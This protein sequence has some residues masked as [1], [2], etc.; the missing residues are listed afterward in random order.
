[1]WGT[2]PKKKGYLR[3]DGY[4]NPRRPRVTPRCVNNTGRTVVWHVRSETYRVSLEE[5]GVIKREPDDLESQHGPDKED[6]E[7]WVDRKQGSRGV[8]DFSEIT[9]QRAVQQLMDPQMLSSFESTSREGE[10]TGLKLTV[11]LSFLTFTVLPPG[12]RRD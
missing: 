8:V 7:I 2:L 11:T 12:E 5:L 6:R 10:G 4:L 3:H 9:C 1:M